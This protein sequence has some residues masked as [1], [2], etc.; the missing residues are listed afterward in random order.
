MS[1]QRHQRRKS[2]SSPKRSFQSASP[3]NVAAQAM[4]KKIA[5]ADCKPV[6]KQDSK[7]ALSTVQNQEQ[8]RAAFALEMVREQLNCYKRKHSDNAKKCF[9]SAKEL[10]SHAA[11][12]PVMIR[13]NGLGQAA[14][15]Y[16]SKKDCHHDLYAMV[17]EWL[18]QSGKPYYGKQSLIEGITQDDM[19][20]YL[21][22]QAEAQALLVW[23]KRLANVMTE[24]SEPEAAN[25]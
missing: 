19:W 9:D 1:R 7:S 13:M 18:T 20:T 22:A 17:S 12:F 8:Q 4:D 5:S 14:A 25:G 6:C 21:L 24:A 15:F 3:V 23:I 11:A 16:C 10:A 2:S